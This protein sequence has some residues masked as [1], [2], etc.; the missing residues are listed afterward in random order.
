M[1][2]GHDYSALFRALEKIDYQGI[3]SIEANTFVDYRKIWKM[4]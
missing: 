3:L 1:N 4:G 2:D